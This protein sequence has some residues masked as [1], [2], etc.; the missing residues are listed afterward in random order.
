MPEDL[1][2][3]SIASCSFCGKRHDEVNKLVAGHDVNICDQCIELCGQIIAE[4]RVRTAPVHDAE[5]PK[6]AEINA[7]AGQLNIRSSCESRY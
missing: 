5:I 6:P 4:D 2:K 3:T 1:D 7:R